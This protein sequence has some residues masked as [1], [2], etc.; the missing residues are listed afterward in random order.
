MRM[1]RY[2][3]ILALTI[4]VTLATT[5]LGFGHDWYIQAVDYHLARPGSTYLYM[6]WGHSLPL[7]DPIDAAKIAKLQVIDSSGNKADI[8]VAEGRS[9]HCTPIELAQPGI[10][11]ISGQSTPGYYCM[12]LDKNQQMHHAVAPLDEIK[13]AQRVIMSVLAHQYPKTYLSV[14]KLENLDV[15]A[16]VGAKLEIIPQEY[17]G[18]LH[19]GDRLRFQVLYEGSPVPEGTS[20]DATYLGYSPEM[21]DYLFTSRPLRDGFGEVDLPNAGVWY[22]RVVYSVDAPAQLQTKCRQMFYNATLTFLVRK[23]ARPVPESAH[24]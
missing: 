8:P 7:D 19:Q 21:E 3:D 15:P 4:A 9:Y 18:A 17:P 6:G 11:T 10:Y 24:H 12:Y 23:K 13:D 1:S 14:G 20:F 5:A 2:L 22:I 16:F